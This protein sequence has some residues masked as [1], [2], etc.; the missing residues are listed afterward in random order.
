[1]RKIFFRHFGNLLSFFP[2][3]E[4]PPVTDA[5]HEKVGD[6]EDVKNSIV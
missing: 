1:M 5:T 3:I 2:S 6:K 4:I